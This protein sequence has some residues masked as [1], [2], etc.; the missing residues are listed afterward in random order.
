MTLRS[1][2]LSLF[3]EGPFHRLQVLLRLMR[4]PNPDLPRR[5]LTL[6]MVVWLPLVILTAA[7]HADHLSSLL[8]DYVLYSRMVIAVPALL[9]GQLAMD[10]RFRILLTHVRDAHLLEPAE[11]QKL[12]DR[13]ARLRRP[14]D[15]TLAELI[16][17]GLIVV[18]IALIGP[19][20]VARG[21]AWALASNGHGV[22][23]APAG[24]YYL[25]VSIPI[26]QF[27]LL[28]NIW[29]W[30][31]WSYL[32][33]RLS[34][35]N[36]QLAATHPDEHGGLGFLGLAPSGFIPTAIALAATIGGAW[37]YEI[38]HEGTRLASYALPAV[39]L[40]AIIFLF[41]LGPLCFFVPR[42]YQVRSSALLAYGVIAQQHVRYVQSK[43]VGGRASRESAGLDPG[44]V[45][46][47]ALFGASYDR[48][49]R[50][51]PV[52]IDKSTLIGLA[53]S[54]VVPL[55]PVLLAE[56]PLSVL[57]RALIKAVQAA[58]V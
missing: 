45:I 40:L 57:I 41:E 31:V 3:N 5:A 11:E 33:F 35:M 7:T 25:V 53:L 50:M 14:R 30:L 46:N 24:W 55:F 16:I 4:P 44:D 2:D 13:L 58:P 52:P 22:G 20:R 43:W 39:G 10:A 56:I 36:L 8:R 17:I 48:I 34:R 28:L 54:V 1:D 37:R 42:L 29:K 38:L 6:L 51:A 47:L 21:S 15:A 12:D 49:R 23:L 18:E 32:M 9:I 26:Y 27:L 19:D